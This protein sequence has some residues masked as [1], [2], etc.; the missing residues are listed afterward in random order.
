MYVRILKVLVTGANSSIGR[1]L[2]E[3][4]PSSRY[5]LIG[6]VRNKSIEQLP[7]YDTLLHWQFGDC[8]Y[9]RLFE[10]DPDVLIHLAFDHTD[11]ETSVDTILTLACNAQA[12][13]V[14]QIFLSPIPQ[15][16]NNHE[17]VTGQHNLA[18]SLSKYVAIIY[19]GYVVDAGRYYQDLAEYVNS[20]S[21]WMHRMKGEVK[22]AITNVEPLCQVFDKVLKDMDCGSVV[23][24]EDK[25]LVS[26][27][28]KNI[29][30]QRQRA[31]FRFPLPFLLE[32]IVRWFRRKRN[33]VVPVLVKCSIPRKY[34][35]KEY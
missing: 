27:L 22:I 11:V 7:G 15:G 32:V 9:T 1:A 16:G 17:S 18:R 2:G 19:T 34:G 30:M 10:A 21:V 25:I 33:V 8:E 23:Y 6:T 20:T 14:K 4:L 13:G 12:R 3:L 28:A 35:Q 5:E 31:M 24:F 29:A 26:G